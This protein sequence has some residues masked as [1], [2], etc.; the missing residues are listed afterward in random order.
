MG[1]FKKKPKIGERKSSNISQA[2][3]P[4][5]KKLSIPDRV[6]RRKNRSSPMALIKPAKLKLP[7]NRWKKILAIVLSVG[8][9]IY[10]IY[11]LFFSDYFSIEKYSVEEEGTV[12][13]NNDVINQILNQSLGKNLAT[14]SE[15]EI[16]AQIK[17]VEPEIQKLRIIKVFPK[18][19]KVQYEKFPTVAN[20]IDTVGGVQKKFL[21]D[22]QGFITEENAENPNLPYLK[23]ETKEVLPV[24]TTFLQDPKR[25]AERLNYAL[26]TINL[27]EEK[28]GMKILHAQFKTRERE[29]HLYTE[30][31]FYVML[32]MEK[33]IKVQLDKLKKA[34]PKL[35]I[36]N[37]PLQYIDLRIS[38]NN[39][40][41]IIFKRKK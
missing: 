29:L 19:L 34:L 17:T 3:S 35:D 11:A 13:D 31:Y 6:K 38:G 22:S 16:I 27:Y 23:I 15:G 12:I 1:L 25:S 10:G 4:Y 30:K 41:K 32:D 24:R 21:L 39:V 33:D 37:T 14:L 8:I 20:L 18:T 28:F 26:Q 36:Y 7:S 40:E 5:L 2:R 9:I